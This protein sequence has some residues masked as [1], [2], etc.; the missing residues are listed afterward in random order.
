MLKQHPQEELTEH[1]QEIFDLLVPPDH[2]LR[3]VKEA[4]DFE[5]F[6][7]LLEP[8]YSAHRGRPAVDPVFMLKL[9][10]LA[11]HYGLSDR[12]VMNEAQVN[13]AFR[14]F[15]DLPLGG[16]LPVPSLL[17]QFRQRLGEEGFQAVFDRLIEQSRE[18]GLVKDRLRLKDATHVIANVAIPN[19]IA[20]VGQMRT[21][22][23]KALRAYAPERV[24]EEEAEAARIRQA[25]AD[26]KG[27]E[28][29]A[30]RVAHLERL[31][32]WAEELVKTLGPA[33]AGDR[34]RAALTEALQQAHKVLG[35]RRDPQG[36]DQMRS[37]VDPDARRG[38]HGEYYDGYKL[39]MLVDA[40]SELITALDVLPANGDEAAN[41]AALLAHEEQV[42]GNDVAA[43]SVDGIISQRGAL[44]EELE[45]PAGPGVQVYAPPPP[46]PPPSPE[47]MF[48][49]ND[50][51][52]DET[53]ETLT[54]PAGKQTQRR[55]ANARQTRWRFEFRRRQCRDCPLQARC[56]PTLPA[57]RGRRVYKN[58]Y[59]EAFDRLRARAQTAR[60][61][62][63]RREHPKVERKLAE[64]VR[65]HGGRRARYRRRWRVKIQYLLIGWVVNIKRF[66][67]LCSPAGAPAVPQPA[68]AAG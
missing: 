51:T 11:W 60:Y 33:P 40:D 43:L 53:G 37:V 8:Y 34:Q 55:Y 65:R 63:V 66:V 64:I 3:Q 7:P 49:A 14:Y 13:I 23:L 56:L 41:S 62:E 25:T 29:L 46:P 48:T 59:Q 18:Q 17:S 10:F 61:Q 68:Q 15:L 4:I 16:K 47:G 44:L 24:A 38:K 58:R 45:S 22:L 21:Q 42:H 30:Q 36:P 1:D 26:L 6:R 31:V 12:E 27:E 57:K 52:L 19:T 35:D 2:Y 54:C 28:R 50:F 67:K 5:A 9:E 39:D 20:L 32:A